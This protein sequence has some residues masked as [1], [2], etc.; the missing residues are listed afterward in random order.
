MSSQTLLAVLSLEKTPSL[1]E[2]LLAGLPPDVGQWKP[3]SDRWSISEVLAHLVDIERLYAER[4]RKMVAED[5]PMLQKYAQPEGGYQQASA[6]EHLAH[7]LAARRTH[8]P[9][10]RALQ[11][12]AEARIGIHSELGE[13]TLAHMLNEWASHDL[14]H[15]R[16]IAELYRARAFYPH[17]GPYQRYSNP[18][19]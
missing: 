4:A 12:E 11:P 16:Q 14:G 7:F 5:A 6:Q 13:I 8:L 3:A 10:L 17:S 9:F 1:L 15:L 19:P 18:K 2:T